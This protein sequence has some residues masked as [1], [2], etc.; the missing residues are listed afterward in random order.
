MTSLFIIVVRNLNIK[1]FIYDV[2]VVSKR[3]NQKLHHL[4]RTIMGYGWMVFMFLVVATIGGGFDAFVNFDKYGGSYTQFF[5]SGFI[6]YI[7]A[8][9]GIIGII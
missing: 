4:R 2:W 3:E 5:L 1:E 7:I 9:V 8:M 6:A